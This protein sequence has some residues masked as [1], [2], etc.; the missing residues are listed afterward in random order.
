MQMYMDSPSILAWKYD[1]LSIITF[2]KAFLNACDENRDF[3][4]QEG[5]KLYRKIAEDIHWS[6]RNKLT[7]LHN[8]HNEKLGE[9]SRLYTAPDHAYDEARLITFVDRLTSCGPNAVSKF[10]Y[11]PVAE[12]ARM[13]RKLKIRPFTKV[14]EVVYTGI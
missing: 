6:I 3:Y 1:V 5:T 10:L 7:E 8:L 13:A 4:H 2:W 9:F 12:S 11:G 14:D